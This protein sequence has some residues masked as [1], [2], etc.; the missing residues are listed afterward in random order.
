MTEP[1]RCPWQPRDVV[2]PCPTPDEHGACLTCALFPDSRRREVAAA[3]RP[4][5][6]VPGNCPYRACTPCGLAGTW[7]CD[8]TCPHWPHLVAV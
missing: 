1:R 5:A 4:D 8:E 6:A 7:E 3:T 2:I